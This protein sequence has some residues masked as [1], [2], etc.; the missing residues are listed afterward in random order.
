MEGFPST[1]ELLGAAHVTKLPGFGEREAL[2]HAMATVTQSAQEMPIRFCCAAA[3][4]MSV[5]GLSGRAGTSFAKAGY[6]VIGF[7]LAMYSWMREQ[8]AET[9]DIVK[10]GWNLIEPIGRALMPREEEVSDA[11]GFSEAAEAG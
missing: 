9:A 3:V 10:A 4:G 11:V 8:G 5:Q 2:I 1:V 6:D 7:G